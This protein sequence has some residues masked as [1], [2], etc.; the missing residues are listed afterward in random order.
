MYDNDEYVFLLDEEVNDSSIEN[1]I[2]QE[3]VNRKEKERR[4]QIKADYIRKQVK[5]I[6][7]M[8]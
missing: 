3:V 6:Q 5:Q 1:F 2:Y 4:S 7:M 8:I